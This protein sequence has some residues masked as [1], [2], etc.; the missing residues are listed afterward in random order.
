MSNG[1]PQDIRVVAEV[2]FVD[3]ITTMSDPGIPLTTLEYEEWGNPA[4]KRHFDAMMSYSPYDNVTAQSYPPMPVTAALNDSQVGFHEPAKWVARLRATKTDNNELLL[5]TN[6]S[7]GHTG[8]PGRF[9]SDEQNARIMAWL[10]AQSAR[11][12]LH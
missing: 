2:P 7:S 12:H 1:S 4:I 6:M 3:V 5:V 11:L 9:G 10:I 8:K